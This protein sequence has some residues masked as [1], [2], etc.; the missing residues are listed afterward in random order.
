MSK[1]WSSHRPCFLPSW[2][3]Q[4]RSDMES[5]YS[6]WENKPAVRIRPM[7]SEE[8]V[9]LLTY[10]IRDLSWNTAVELS[11]TLLSLWTCA[12]GQLRV[13]PSAAQ[14]YLLLQGG[15]KKKKART[16]HMQL[17]M[18]TMWRRFLLKKIYSS[19]LMKQTHTHRTWPAKK[20]QT[21]MMQRMLKTAE[22][23]MVPT[24]TSPLVMKT[25]ARHTHTRTLC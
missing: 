16:Q 13:G 25:P 12:E 8:A 24:P 18:Q 10:I 6:G 19:P 2:C 9:R 20:P 4:S 22:P 11:H 21:P 15:W 1:I 23:T 3:L 14:C 17:L 7:W 5:F